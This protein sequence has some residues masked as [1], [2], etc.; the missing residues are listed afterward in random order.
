MSHQCSIEKQDLPKVEVV[1]DRIFLDSYFIQTSYTRILHST[2]KQTRI[3]NIFETFE[4]TNRQNEGRG[5]R[6]REEADPR[7]GHFVEVA[8][9]QGY[10]LLNNSTPLLIP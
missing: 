9:E 4:H 1:S 2:S 6:K 3:S 8:E 5:K 7:V 10:G